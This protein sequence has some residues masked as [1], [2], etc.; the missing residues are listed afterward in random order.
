MPIYRDDVLG[1]VERLG[2]AIRHARKNLEE[3]EVKEHLQ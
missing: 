1:I 3:E 2:I